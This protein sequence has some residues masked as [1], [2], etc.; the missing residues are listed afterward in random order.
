MPN[1]PLFYPIADETSAVDLRDQL[2]IALA[3]ADATALK[4]LLINCLPSIAAPERIGA[5]C[6]EVGVPT[7][8]QQAAD[9]I[10]HFEAIQCVLATAAPAV[11]PH[12]SGGWPRDSRELGRLTQH[13]SEMQTLGHHLPLAPTVSLLAES[14]FCSK[15]IEEIL[16]LPQDGWHKTWWYA[17]DH[18]GD[19]TVPFLRHIRILRYPDGCLSIQYRD[20]FEQDNPGCF[21][22]LPQKALVFLR[23][24]NC[25]FGETLR[26]INDQRQALG[27]SRVILVCNTIA[28]L[29]AQA[30]IRQGIS[31]YSAADLILP[32][33]SNCIHCGRHECPMNGTINSPVAL[34]HG[35]LPQSEFV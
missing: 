3:I 35:Y 28:E 10:L 22:R 14:G 25:G 6:A 13:E 19:F 17:I 16:R 18:R 2:Q 9:G 34:C 11:E 23:S 5:V 33:Q 8:D 29:E 15:Q 30:F 4:S 32:T 24:P 1:H 21:T 31:I 26:Q 12:L 20:F 7:H 27:I